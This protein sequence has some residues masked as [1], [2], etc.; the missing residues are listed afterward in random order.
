MRVSILEFLLV[1]RVIRTRVWIKEPV[2]E[3]W[4]TMRGSQRG[5]G[6]GHWWPIKAVFRIRS[7]R[8]QSWQDW[9]TRVLVITRFYQVEVADKAQ[10]S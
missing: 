6:R 3:I 9:R 2:R 5:S 8:D 10:I 4:I 1:I 7:G